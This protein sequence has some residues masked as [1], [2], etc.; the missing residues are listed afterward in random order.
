MKLLNNFVAESQAAISHLILRILCL[1]IVEHECARLVQESSGTPAIAGN[2]VLAALFLLAAVLCIIMPNKV[3]GYATGIIVA[4][5]NI[6]AK[7]FIIF[8][9]HE[10]FPY[11]PIVWISQCLLV[12][13]FCYQALK[14]R[15]FNAKLKDT[16]A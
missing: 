12:V 3:V 2:Y 16:F 7:V 4:T 1:L 11:Y 8:A 5:I 10:H 15:K 13:Y 6:V 14:Q 9:G